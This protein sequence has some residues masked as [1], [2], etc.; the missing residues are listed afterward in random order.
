MALRL[1][2]LI[3]R[4]SFNVCIYY[5]EF[6]LIHQTTTRLFVYTR[7]VERCRFRTRNECLDIIY[8]HTSL[9]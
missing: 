2:G 7:G 1:K 4:Q 5:K 9:T 8:E 6:L 3:S